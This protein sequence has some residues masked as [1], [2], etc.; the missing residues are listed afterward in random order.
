MGSLRF[1]TWISSPVE[2]MSLAMVVPVALR[3]SESVTG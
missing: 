2:D 3:D 1:D